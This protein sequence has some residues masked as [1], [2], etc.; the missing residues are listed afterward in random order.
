MAPTPNSRLIEIIF[1][2][3]GTTGFLKA[4]HD[5]VPVAERN[6]VFFFKRSSRICFDT[7]C[8]LS[9]CIYD[10]ITKPV[11]SALR[12]MRNMVR[13]MK[14]TYQYIQPTSTFFQRSLTVGSLFLPNKG[15][16]RVLE[17]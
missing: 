11:T 13:T 14:R 12:N 7:C 4:K 16:G 1:F 9:H 6:L 2:L 15:F 5:G 3:S 17:G 8:D 10:R